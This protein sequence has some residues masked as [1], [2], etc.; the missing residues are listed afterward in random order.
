MEQPCLILT[1]VI[2][3]A[4]HSTRLDYRP[5]ESAEALHRSGD[6]LRPKEGL[7][8]PDITDTIQVLSPKAQQILSLCAPHASAARQAYGSAIAP[9]LSH[10]KRYHWQSSGRRWAVLHAFQPSNPVHSLVVSGDTL[11][12]MKAISAPHYCSHHKGLGAR[13]DGSLSG[14]RT[15]PAVSQREQPFPPS[16]IVLPMPAPQHPLI[17]KGQPQGNFA[18]TIWP[19]GIS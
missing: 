8:F 15:C 13:S 4:V 9:S 3:Q 16:W 10:T 12:Q 14:R 6:M 5:A 7:G 18:Q 19:L 2:Q 1:K 11:G 17:M